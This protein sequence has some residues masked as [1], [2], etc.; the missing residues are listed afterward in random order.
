MT[1]IFK[2][3]ARIV[4]SVGIKALREGNITIATVD[5]PDHLMMKKGLIV[6]KI[7]PSDS[8]LFRHW[9]ETWKEKKDYPKTDLE[10]S[11][12]FKGKPR[13]LKQNSL[14]W[15][16]VSVLAM[17]V[18]RERGWEEVVH[19][20]LLL[21]YSPMVESKLHGASVPKRSKD[22]DT[23]EFTRLIEGAMHEINE[24]GISI[25]EP[26]DM[27]QYWKDY[28][29]LRWTNG[30]D[31]G[32]RAEETVEEYRHRINYCEACHKYMRPG[33]GQYDGNLAHIVSRGAGGI[34]ET[35]NLLHLCSRDHIQIQH[36][37]GW[38]EFLMKYPHLSEKVMIAI[39]RHIK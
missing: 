28:A 35:W 2:G 31:H 23:A 12:K 14:Y 20:E 32:Y 7:S 22:L 4:P 5:N 13:S 34:D 17:E 21:M 18:Y 29:R 26:A 38:K 16:L 15:A 39:G 1:K 36:Q 37:K 6:L 10:I 11:L 8:G 33:S 19:E 30:I 24:Q 25:T 3:G 9:I 27:D